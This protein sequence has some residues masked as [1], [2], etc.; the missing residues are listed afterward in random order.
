[1]PVG[2]FQLLPDQNPLLSTC[3]VCTRVHTRSVGTPSSQACTVRAVII[4]MPLIQSHQDSCSFD[5]PLGEHSKRSPLLL[6]WES[7][8]ASEQWG[9]VLWGEEE[10]KN[11]TGFRL[12]KG[13]RSAMKRAQTFRR[14][15]AFKKHNRL[16]SCQT[17]GPPLLRP[18]QLGPH[19]RARQDTP[20]PLPQIPPWSVEGVHAFYA[21]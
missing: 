19:G 11:K 3:S 14:C 20:C 4:Q 18:A 6:M 17:R 8:G 7:L 12:H 13:N 5:V 1:M 10:K 15:K 21:S 16:G 9:H 2:E